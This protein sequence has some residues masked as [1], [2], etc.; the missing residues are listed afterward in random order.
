MQPE[1]EIPAGIVKHNKQRSVRNRRMNPPRPAR[2]LRNGLSKES[3]EGSGYSGPLSLLKPSADKRIR[4]ID[5]PL[6][7]RHKHAP[8]RHKTLQIPK[9]KVYQG[10]ATPGSIQQEQFANTAE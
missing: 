1:M 3:S 7:V 4:L 5:Q 9:E 2:A 8:S 10:R 6:T